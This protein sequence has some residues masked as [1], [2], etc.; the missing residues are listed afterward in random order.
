MAPAP[1]TAGLSVFLTYV[2]VQ[3]INLSQKKSSFRQVKDFKPVVKYWDSQLKAKAIILFED[4]DK[5]ANILLCIYLSAILN[6]VDYIFVVRTYMS[7]HPYLY[8]LTANTKA[9]LSLLWSSCLIFSFFPFLYR[10]C[11]SLS[12]W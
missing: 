10:R 3:R 7:I 12:D 9:C 11:L 8:V 1:E 2:L 6:T 4:Q 5:L